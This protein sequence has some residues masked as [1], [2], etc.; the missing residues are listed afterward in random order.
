MNLFTV[1]A[2]VSLAFLA[3]AP[4]AATADEP[5]SARTRPAQARALELLQALTSYDLA[6]TREFVEQSVSPAALATRPVEAWVWP[7]IDEERKI[8]GGSFVRWDHVSDTEARLVY[9]NELFG[10]VEMIGVTIEPSSPHRIIDWTA[11]A[12]LPSDAVAPKSDQ[13][14]AARLHAFAQRMADHDFFSGTVLIAKDGEAILARAYG[15]AERNFKVPNRLDTK[16]K[17]ASINKMF[18]A[19]AIGQLVDQGKVTLDDFL[20]T[21]VPGAP[22]ADR[23][24]V[25]HLLS[26]T[27]GIGDLDYVQ[28]VWH[29][30]PD[31]LRD[32][33]SFMKIADTSAP[34]TE[35]G[36]VWEYNNLGYF[37]LGK[38][39]EKVSGEDYYRYIENRVF[40][41]AGMINSSCPQFDA[42]LANMS[43][44]YEVRFDLGAPAYFNTMVMDGARGGP[45]GCAVSTVEDLARFARALR[46]GTLLQPATFQRFT[47]AIPETGSRSWGLGFYRRKLGKSDIVTI[48]HGG[49]S[50]GVCTQFG[51]F[52]HDGIPWTFAILSNS[53]L[54]ACYPLVAETK[55]LLAQRLT[56][57]ETSP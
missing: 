28:T 17:M 56:A 27:S 21:Y 35:P 53:G 14:L 9:R 4:V 18:T 33:D 29:T 8:R 6:T 32:L 44:P 34:K 12:P 25:R 15:L 1:C 57:R 3:A 52:E 40:K 48:G 47:T 20:A 37:Y 31:D 54:R 50:I 49:N 51:M 55:E 42:A 30:S 19:V 39:I 45:D 26:H 5:S 38:V 22:G 36:T 11:P 24:R 46:N 10:R 16:M 41:P 43:Y 23:V 13:E 2:V 7:L